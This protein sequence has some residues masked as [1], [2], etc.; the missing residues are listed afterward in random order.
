MFKGEKMAEIKHG[1]FGSYGKT[2]DEK[3]K[4][5]LRSLIELGCVKE[6]VSINGIKF[7]LRSLSATEKM[8]ASK[9]LGTDADPEKLFNFN[10]LLLSMAV[11]KVNDVPLE[12]LYEG[13]PTNNILAARQYIIRQLQSSVLSKLLESYAN[14]VE[15]ADSQFT[16]D[17]VKK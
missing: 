3:K 7:E 5:D 15:R 8:E 12:E 10:I 14:L 13:E 4:V 17:Q 11:D 6:I 16:A 2:E 1:T 9:F